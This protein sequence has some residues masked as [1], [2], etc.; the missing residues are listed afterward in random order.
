[1]L[2][3]GGVAGAARS[4]RD[5][6]AVATHQGAALRRVRAICDL[7]EIDAHRGEAMALLAPLRPWLAAAPPA[8]D[9]RRA[10]GLLA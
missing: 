2:L 6:V 7:A 5:A 8:P 4:L 9:V 10:R 3:G 1:M